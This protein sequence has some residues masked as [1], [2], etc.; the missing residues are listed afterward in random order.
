MDGPPEAPRALV[1]V[2]GRT[3]CV[4]R[5]EG[6]ENRA[7]DQPRGTDAETEAYVERALDEAVAKRSR[8][9][10]AGLCGELGRARE[11]HRARACRGAGTGKR[12]ALAPGGFR[13]M[14]ICD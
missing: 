6:A 3:L 11:A 9:E 7:G 1:R 12:G 8:V 4:G 5:D 14:Y 2:D 13:R 10:R